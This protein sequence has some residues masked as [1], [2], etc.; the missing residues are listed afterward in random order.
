[1]V[2]K[3]AIKSCKNTSKDGCHLFKFPKEQKLREIWMEL[4]GVT[5]ITT[6]TSIC[7]HHFATEDYTAHNQHRARLYRNAIPSVFEKPPDDSLNNI[8]KDDSPPSP[9]PK[10]EEYISIQEKNTELESK[11]K[12]LEEQNLTLGSQIK[13]SSKKLTISRRKYKK[14]YNAHTRLRSGFKRI[15]NEQQIKKLT[16]GHL[17][18]EKWSSKNIQIGLKL[19]YACKNRGYKS[20]LKMGLPY[21]SVDSIRKRIQNIHFN[22]GILNDVHSL[23]IP[24]V[25]NMEE[26]EKECVLVIDEMSVKERID[27]NQH[28][29]EMVGRI[30]LPENNSNQPANHAV[31]F[32]LRGLGSPWK[33]T[34][35]FHFTGY[36]TS[37][38]AMRDVVFKIVEKYT[39]IGL[40]VRA[41]ST[42]MGSNNQK[43]WKQLKITCKKKS[44][45][46]VSIE[47]PFLPNEKLFFTPDTP[48]IIKNLR[49]HFLHGMLIKIPHHIVVKNKLP[50]DTVDIC[51]VK[52]VEELEK[53]NPTGMKVC[54]ELTAKHFK[55]DHW[56]LMNVR[57]AAQLIASK[58]VSDGLYFYINE[59][60]LPEEAR[61]TAWFIG[62]MNIWFDLVTDKVR[63]LKHNCKKEIET[64]KEIMDLIREIRI[65]D[66]NDKSYWKPVQ[67]GILIASQTIIEIHQLLTM[68]KNWEYF[69]PGRLTSD[70]IENLFS[71]IRQGNPKPSCVEFIYLLRIVCIAQYNDTPGTGNYDI[72]DSDYL[73]EF[74]HDNNQNTVPRSSKP[75]IKLLMDKADE[76]SFHPLINTEDDISERINDAIFHNFCGGIVR[77]IINKFNCEACTSVMSTEFPYMDEHRLT[78]LKEYCSERPSQIY[79]TPECLDFLKR[80]ENIFKKIKP[81]LESG[82]NIKRDF[83]E[84]CL[85]VNWEISPKCHRLR[86]TLCRVFASTRMG[87]YVKTVKKSHTISK[88]SNLAF[89][90]GGCKNK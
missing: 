20:L 23:M 78:E 76:V 10:E 69:L 83:K 84:Q 63:G 39:E 72:D 49:N 34:V 28:S 7:E 79:V 87:I 21:P 29:D 14:L 37:G 55:P 8:P 54:P 6:R 56:Q 44:S 66:E 58:S 12:M 77:R 19:K 41:V 60:I 5:D 62:K 9:E 59:G 73:V 36:S 52:L 30:T 80:C 89:L 18:G 90:M 17:R 82:S 70:C 11:V 67:R 32:M 57:L 24:K 68:K 38:A 71:V 43:I 22:T 64:L 65:I 48:H 50:T 86:E 15:F 75:D 16:K 26:C 2:V 46:V 53:K 1:M 40:K 88:G 33:Q 3:C 35:A 45:P 27:Y 81:Y 4:T 47:H 31:A 42:D 25:Q 61:T 13:K 51:H 74:L 85:K